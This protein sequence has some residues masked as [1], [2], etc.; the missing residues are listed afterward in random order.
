MGP[1]EYEVV[2]LCQAIRIAYQVCAPWPISDDD[3]YIGR[4]GVLQ[5]DRTMVELADVVL[6]F[7]T[8]DDMESKDF[9]GT[10]HLVETALSKDK[11]VFMYELTKDG[12]RQ[13]G[14]ND[15]NGWSE[16]VPSGTLRP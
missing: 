13:V 2:K 12:V 14:A 15:P 3:P 5:R 10:R 1:F 16:R 9:S 7:V 8:A 4:E 11:S 6:A